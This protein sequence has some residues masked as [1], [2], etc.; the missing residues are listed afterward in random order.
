MRALKFT[1]SNFHTKACLLIACSLFMLTG[2]SSGSASNISNPSS[3]AYTTLNYSTL[4]GT[5]TLPTGIR[6]VTNSTNVYISGIYHDS[7]TAKPQG[8]IY[9]GPILGGGSWQVLNYPG[10]SVTSTSLYGPDNNGSNSIA[11]AG[12]YTTVASGEFQLGLLYQGPVDGSGTWVTL[13]PE[14]LITR[15]NESILNTIAHNTMG[16]LLVGNFDTNLAIGRAFIYNISGQSFIEL[17]KPGAISVTAYGIWYNGG[18]SYTITGG[19]SDTN[20]NGIDIGYLVDW[21]SSS[22]T[23][24]NWESYTFNNQ[25]NSN[26]VTHFEGITTD[27]AGGYNLASDFVNTE[28]V[29][30]AAFVNVSRNTNGTFESNATWVQFSYPNSTLTSAN[31]VYQNYVLGIYTLAT[32]SG[33]ENGYVATIPLN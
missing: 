18:T 1:S 26:F 6:G 19:Y 33:V 24:S 13:N 10:D 20:E 8:L 9:T 21:D 29:T 22:N 5:S 7:L 14:S 4:A 25:L 31:T 30:G 27:G 32:E 11:V 23:A 16:G 3:V 17:R 28:G 12:S 2:C 15:Q